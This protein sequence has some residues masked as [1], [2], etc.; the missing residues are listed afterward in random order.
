[1]LPDSK[2]TEIFFV[3]DEF[4]QVFDTTIKEKSLCDGKAHRNKPC[5]MSESEVATILVLFH[6]GGYRCLKHFYL[7]HVCKHMND[8]FPKTLSYNRF[9][10]LQAKVSVML[11]CF[12]KMCRFGE[13]TG[14]SFVDST[15]L[16][17]CENKRIPAHKVFADKGY[18]SESLFNR[19]FF[20]GIHLITTVRRNM[21]ERY[22][23]QNDRIILRKRAIIETIND[24][25]KNICQIEHTRH[26]SFANFISN[27]IGGLTAYTFLPKKPS[28]NVELEPAAQF[29]IP[30]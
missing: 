10:E 5:K 27:L 21:K 15:K 23:T 17:V 26:R 16:C 24:E 25:L 4:S 19:L 20:D 22:M 2:I 30:S 12:L 13:C 18:I 7:Q 14:I 29:F 3:I 28:I 11:V 6:L 1:M 9:V 8:D